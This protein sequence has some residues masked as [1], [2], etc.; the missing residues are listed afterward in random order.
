MQSEEQ[1][2]PS[3]RAMWEA[4]DADH[5]APLLFSAR[6]VELGLN[7]DTGRLRSSLALDPRVN[8]VLQATQGQPSLMPTSLHALSALVGLEQT[9]RHMPSGEMQPVW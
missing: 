9:R 2:S 7:P 1:L 3:V 8:Q 6:V 4:K 5:F